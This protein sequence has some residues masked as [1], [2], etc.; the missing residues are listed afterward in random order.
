ML[1]SGSKPP[2]TRHGCRPTQY[3]AIPETLSIREFR[4]RIVRPGYRSRTITVATTLLGDKQYGVAE[5]ARP[6]SSSMGCRNQSSFAE[7]D[8]AHGRAS[9]PD[10]PEMVRKEIWAHLLAYNLDPNGDCTGG[11]QARQT[12]AVRSAS[13]EPCA[14]WR[15]SVLAAGPC[16]SS[17]ATASRFTNTCC[18]PSR[19]H[20]IA[21]R[22]NRL[23]TTT[24][25]TPTETI[26][27]HEQTA[28]PSPKA[29]SQ[30]TLAKF[31][32]HSAL[33]PHP[34]RFV[35]VSPIPPSTP[36]SRWTRVP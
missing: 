7:N 12:S 22:P 21:N 9:L 3:A 14:P 25:Q 15:L 13:H 26:Q 24:T 5:I 32:C 2:A 19:T 27:T 23:G 8:D 18:K 4:C 31:Q 33:T 29:R 1:S 30:N 35:A 11:V 10:S 20:E 16:T 36:V 17:Q 28:I 34:V 6:L